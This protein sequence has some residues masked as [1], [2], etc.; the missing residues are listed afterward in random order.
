MENNAVLYHHGIKGQRW[1]VRRF[2]TKDGGLT[3]AGRKRYS[4][5]ETIH[6]Y[7]VKKKRKQA[8]EK[9]RLAKAAKAEHE[10]K[11][12]EGKVDLKDMTDDEIRKAIARKQLENAYTQLHPKQVSKGE[13]FAKTVLNDMIKPAAV[14]SGRQ[15]LQDY[16]NKVGKDL[17][18]DKVDPNSIEALQK[19]YTKLDLQKKIKDLKS[20]KSSALD[21]LAEKAKV[22]EY[23]K[24]IY[25]TDKA[26]REYESRQRDDAEAAAKKEAESKES[27]S[28]PKNDSESSNA[29][30]SSGKSGN[31]SSKKNKKD[32]KDTDSVETAP[33]DGK[34]YGE[35]TSRSSIKDAMD[36]GKKWWDT[37][38]VS[39]TVT[40]DDYMNSPSKR[41][42]TKDFVNSVSDSTALAVVN[43]S[44]REAAQSYID[45]LIDM[46][47]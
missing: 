26:R 7:K 44:S 46:R 47:I 28:K 12:V 24:K 31:K 36:N 18:K 2:Q 10:K 16:L 34:V 20:G 19:Q 9:A 30:Q 15:F 1:G 23:E 25:E 8:A 38:N 45:R 22:A 27:S 13:A 14:N 35:G 3:D 33:T 29:E 41:S 4:L 39:D 43:A 6:N 42:E 21:E 17:L 5:G 37:N 32:T 11:A 40:F